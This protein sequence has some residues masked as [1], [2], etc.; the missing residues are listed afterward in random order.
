[1]IGLRETPQ[2]TK[3][4]LAYCEEEQEINTNKVRNES[5]NSNVNDKELDINDVMCDIKVDRL[6]VVDSGEEIDFTKSNDEDKISLRQSFIKQVVMMMKCFT[7]LKKRILH[8]RNEGV[9]LSRRLLVTFTEDI[10]LSGLN[11]KILMTPID[12]SLWAGAL[13]PDYTNANID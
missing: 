7:N 11:K 8:I 1:M 5:K 6:E 10:T 13:E 9:S 3:E 4:E 12:E 2:G